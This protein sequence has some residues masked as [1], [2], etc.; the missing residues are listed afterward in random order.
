MGDTF[1]TNAEQHIERNGELTE[2]VER[3]TRRYHVLTSKK[4]NSV[5]EELFEKMEDIVALNSRE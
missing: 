5:T 3:C 4:S 1:G 2:L